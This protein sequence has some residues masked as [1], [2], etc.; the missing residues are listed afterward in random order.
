[1]S[2][3]SLVI[4]SA[5]KDPALKG[6]NIHRLSAYSERLG[7]MRDKIIPT[8]VDAGFDEVI[9]C[10]VYEAGNGYRYVPMAPRRRDRRDALHQRDL[11][12]AYATGDI[13]VFCHDDHAPAHDFVEKLR[14]AAAEPWD[15]LVPQ[16][17]HGI[18]DAVLDNGKAADYM[19]GHCL[20]MRR[21]L[22]AEVPWTSVDT[23]WWDVPMT[24]LWREAGGKIAWSDELIHYD[25]EATENEA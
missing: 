18:T 9:V 4:N 3:L 14:S 20:A 1:M 11:G 6:S 12:A 23:E 10:G 16:R 15:I 8:V 21:W 7:L 24:R 25:L 22:W 19:G 5:A 2:K 17:R 13:L